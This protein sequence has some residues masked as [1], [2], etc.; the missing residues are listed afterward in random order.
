MRHSLGKFGRNLLS[1]DV[2]VNFKCVELKSRDY[3]NLCLSIPT[4]KPL[5]IKMY[6]GLKGVSCDPITQLQ[7]I[8]RYVTAKRKR[9]KKRKKKKKRKEKC[10]KKEE[11]KTEYLKY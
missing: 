8:R 3:L 11:I 4:S 9:K 2:A 7:G 10:K 1:T 5:K 6:L